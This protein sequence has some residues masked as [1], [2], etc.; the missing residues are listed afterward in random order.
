[1]TLWLLTT[2]LLQFK[3]PQMMVLLLPFS[4]DEA[5]AESLATIAEGN[6]MLASI[7]ISAADD[8]IMRGETAHLKRSVDELNDLDPVIDPDL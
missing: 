8:T 5:Y 4:I 3:W 1:M 6:A 7:E 2:M